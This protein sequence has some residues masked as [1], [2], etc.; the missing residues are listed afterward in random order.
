V[1]TRL[2]TAAEM[3]EAE[4]R[5][6]EPAVFFPNWDGSDDPEVRIRE[7]ASAVLAG[8]A[9][10]DERVSLILDGARTVLARHDPAG[11]G[12]SYTSKKALAALIRYIAD[13]LRDE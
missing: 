12:G 8:R 10:D 4:P 5:S 9:P 11:D 3:L 2:V 13:T 1:V 7:G 6:D